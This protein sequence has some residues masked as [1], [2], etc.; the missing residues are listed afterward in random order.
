MK[1]IELSLHGSVSTGQEP[2]KAVWKKPK[3]P[4]DT[5]QAWL[6][7]LICLFDF[8]LKVRKTDPQTGKSSSH[9]IHYNRNRDILAALRDKRRWMHISRLSNSMLDAHW[10]GDETFYFTAAG[11]SRCGEILVNLD[12]DCHGSGS[13][14]GAFEAAEHLK[15]NF[16]PRLYHEPST[17]GR[18]RHGYFVL[19]KSGLDAE[20]VKELLK[21][22]ERCLNEHL[23]SLGFDIELFEIK[24]LPPVV[25]WNDDGE[26]TNY[27]AGILAKIPRQVHRFEEWKRT[28]KLTDLDVRRVLT[29][30]RKLS[31]AEV[32]VTPK[33]ATAKAMV[34]E[35]PT[36]GSSTGK[37]IGEDEL[38]QLAEGRRY[39]NVAT[40]FLGAHTLKTT[41]RTVVT[42]E[43]VAVFLMCLKFF[44]GRM[45]VDGTLPVK[46]FEG[47]W[48]ALYE[49]RD[50]GRAFDCHRFK[51]IRDYL[52]DL[53]LLDWEDRTFVAPRN[54]RDGTKRNGRACKW[55]AGEVL[56]GMLDWESCNLAGIAT[57]EQSKQEK[58]E[59]GEAPLVGA[60]ASS[61]SSSVCETLS[62]FIQSLEVVLEGE[63]IRPIEVE[64]LEGRSLRLFSPEDI[65]VLVVNFEDSM[66]RIAA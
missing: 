28:T 9:P 48:S 18:G 2:R 24:G 6:R 44:T 53:G 62:K 30:L 8:G 64:M 23:L 17:N 14:R 60:E 58:G 3:K 46:R 43:D 33:Q 25:T 56:M 26:V 50:V 36:S 61:S 29:K 22:L 13:E 40:T 38:A 49:E 52:S 11:S 41:N 32:T 42:A 1:E 51:A 5:P 65:T 27:T 57:K 63:E 7:R 35:K 34:V 16:F 54:D 19:E 45:N 47:L 20:G 55:K 10:S 39:L 15:A 12:I 31:P 66:G 37:V 4:R 59:D 21:R